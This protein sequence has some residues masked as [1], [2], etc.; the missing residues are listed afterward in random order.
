MCIF[1]PSSKEDSIPILLHV[2]FI[3]S[4]PWDFHRRICFY[5]AQPT[6]VLESEFDLRLECHALGSFLGPA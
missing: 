5:A 1:S 2:P 3:H 6:T 4:P